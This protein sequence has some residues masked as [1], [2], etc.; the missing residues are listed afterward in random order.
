MTKKTKRIIGAAATGIVWLACFALAAVKAAPVDGPELPEACRELRNPEG[1]K[2][3]FNV[4]AKGD[5]IYRWNGTAWVL[6]APD[7]K[8]FVN[9]NYQGLV[10]THFA[11]PTWESNSGSSVVAAR[12]KDCTPDSSAIPWL[13]LQKVVTDGPG[14]F[15]RVTHIQRVNTTGGLKPLAPG[16]TIGDEIAVPYTAEYYFYRAIGPAADAN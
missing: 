2:L 5:Q 16:T 4:Y 1:T 7:A 3:A 12:L 6:R 11:G 13:L 14:I 8:L 15:S 10:G 9:E